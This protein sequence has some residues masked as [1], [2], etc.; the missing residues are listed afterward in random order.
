MTKASIFFIDVPHR[1]LLKCNPAKPGLHPKTIP[2]VKKKISVVTIF[3]L[4]VGRVSN[5]M[6][7]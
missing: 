2:G 5:F 4:L 1:A 3:L 7:R 6:L